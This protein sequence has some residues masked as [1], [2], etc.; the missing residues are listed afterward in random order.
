MACSWNPSTDTKKPPCLC[1]SGLTVL[2]TA[3]MG[4]LRHGREAHG[5]YPVLVVD[6]LHE[7]AVLGLAGRRRHGLLRLGRLSSLLL[8]LLLQDG[9]QFEGQGPTAYRKSGCWPFPL[10]HSRTR[11]VQGTPTP[12]CSL[13]PSQLESSAMTP[14]EL[15]APEQ[16]M[17]AADLRGGTGHFLAISEPQ[18]PHPENGTRT[19][20]ALE[21]GASTR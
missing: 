3:Q 9:G 18:L 15:A 16:A 5:T 6:D 14:A 19:V 20:S 2:P 11:A 7:A 17:S 21:M 1:C 10:S 4:T 12:C 13:Q 8:Q